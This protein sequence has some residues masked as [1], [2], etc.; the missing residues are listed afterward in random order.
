[1]AVPSLLSVN[2][3]PFG[4]SPFSDSAAVGKP[5]VLIVELPGLPSEKVAESPEVMLGASST[6]SVK[7]CVAFGLMPLLALSVNE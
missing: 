2:V 4:R 3:T 7:D 5:E 1:M 6:V